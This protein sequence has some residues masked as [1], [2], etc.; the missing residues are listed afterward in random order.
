MLQRM[1]HARKFMQEYDARIGQGTPPG[2][3]VGHAAAALGERA[4][5]PA[6]D[7][8]AVSGG[9]EADAVPK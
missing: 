2:E 3:A 4:V 1:F 7:G 6:L 5:R 8:A 9:F